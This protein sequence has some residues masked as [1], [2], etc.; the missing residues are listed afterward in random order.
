MAFLSERALLEIAV[1]GSTLGSLGR[2]HLPYEAAPVAEKDKWGYVKPYFEK[3]LRAYVAKSRS[4]EAARVF[5]EE[6]NLKWL[7]SGK[8]IVSYRSTFEDGDLDSIIL[9]RS[10]FQKANSCIEAPQRYLISLDKKVA[11]KIKEKFKLSLMSEHREKLKTKINLLVESNWD[12]LSQ[13]DQDSL[14]TLSNDFV[15]D[16]IK[17][18]NAVSG[19][20]FSWRAAW[21]NQE[22]SWDRACENF[23][24]RLNNLTA[25][26]NRVRAQALNNT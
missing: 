18:V 12:E 3:L 6:P 13:L 16:I 23:I 1:V 11:D 9:L 15:D 19:C 14:N 25:T 10:E 20:V 2:A 24:D 8:G 21:I 7:L 17:D 26:S 22:E 5:C 4:Y